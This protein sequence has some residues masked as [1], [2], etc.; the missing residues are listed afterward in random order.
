M[1]IGVKP[2][3]RFQKRLRGVNHKGDPK[4]IKWKANKFF[5]LLLKYANKKMYDTAF[6][7]KM[8][9]RKFYMSGVG[10]LHPDQL[11]PQKHY[12]LKTNITSDSHE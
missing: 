12:M 8:Y 4:F 3:K 9:M 5:E 10:V 1:L 2:T 6:I 11:P 7:S